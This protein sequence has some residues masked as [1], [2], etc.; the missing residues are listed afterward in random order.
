MTPNRAWVRLA[1]GR[2]INLLDPQPDSWTDIDLAIGLSR[3]YRWGGHS[4]W[5]L[6]LSV[7]QHSLTVLAL[8]ERMHGRP[9]TRL[10]G[11]RELL[12]DASEGLLSFDPISPVKPHL[13]TSFKQL[14]AR[15]QAAIATR[16]GLQ[17]W[18]EDDYAAH[19]RAD[20]LA[21]ASEALH[22]AGWSRDEIRDTLLVA[23]CP[24]TDDPLPALEGLR[25]WEPWPA[26]LA[27]SLFLAKLREL[28]AEES[29]SHRP[30]DLTAIVAR[31][32]TLRRLAVA[33]A[34]LPIKMRGSC[35]S[36]P[37]GSGLHDTFVYAEAADGSQSVEGVVVAGARDETGAWVFEEP[38]KIFTTDEDLL[39]C[40]GYNCH[41]EIQ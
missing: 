9:L 38:F 36:P 13:G 12:H 4:T 21:A 37:L 3:T 14:D 41:V 16:Y 10:D 5:D 2:R 11:L 18:C 35:T 6:P 20:R 23:D 29:F 33:F 39:V 25:S 28:L 22:V 30:G 40:Q 17:P 8:R 7:A 19:K 15:L 24:L 32:R 27:A 34:R 26:P 1:S 31:E